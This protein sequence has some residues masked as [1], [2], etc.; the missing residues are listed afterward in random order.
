MF[1]HLIITDVI[2]LCSLITADNLR[3]ILVKNVKTLKKL[4]LRS[5]SAAQQ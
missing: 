1:E 2:T 3:M 5:L 4:R